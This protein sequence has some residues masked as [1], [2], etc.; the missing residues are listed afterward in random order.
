MGRGMIKIFREILR[1]EKSP[2]GGFSFAIKIGGNWRGRG[3]GLIQK[4][5]LG[6]N[7]LHKGGNLLCIKLWKNNLRSFIH[8]SSNNRCCFRVEFIME[9]TRVELGD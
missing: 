2:Q 6:G 8:N 9:F 1:E 7:S 4:N 5:L 3:F